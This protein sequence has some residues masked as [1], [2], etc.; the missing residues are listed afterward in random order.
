MKKK[1]KHISIFI[2]IEIIYVMFLFSNL[3][4]D[5][6]NYI[7]TFD[8]HFIIRKD[9]IV[10]V[11]PKDDYRY[12]LLNYITINFGYNKN[13]GFNIERYDY[14]YQNLYSNEERKE[15]IVEDDM[16]QVEMKYTDLNTIEYSILIARLKCKDDN[17]EKQPIFYRGNLSDYEW[18]YIFYDYTRT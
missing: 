14:F 6:I 15:Q 11:I 8:K 2:F 4:N 13:Y 9:E 16:I 3:P 17:M 12:N 18:H 7:L 5:L 1:Y 10:S